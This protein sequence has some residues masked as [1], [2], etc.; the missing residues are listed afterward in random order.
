MPTNGSEV[1]III[2]DDESEERVPTK[3]TRTTSIAPSHR[4]HSQAYSSPTPHNQSWH[5]PLAR[6]PLRVCSAHSAVLLLLMLLPSLL[7]HPSNALLH[8]RHEQHPKCSFEGSTCSTSNAH[9]C[10]NGTCLSA[11]TFR[12]MKE[13]RCDMEEDDYC[14][15]C[16]GSAQERCLPAHEHGILRDNGERWERESCSWCRMQGTEREGM[17]CDDKDPQRLCLHGKCSKSVCA[18]KVQG[19]FCDRK[20]EKI[21][22]DDVCENPCARIAP[23]LMVCDCPAIDPDTGFASEDRCQLCCHDYHQKPASRRCQNAFRKYHL[24][25]AQ[26][27]PIWRIGLECAGG[28]RCNRFGICS[29]D[30]QLG[31]NGKR[32]PAIF[33]AVALFVFAVVAVLTTAAE[34]F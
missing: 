14:F 19:Q 24:K 6:F 1:V 21:C 25:S 11:C 26:E 5:F 8:H 13:C 23:H 2:A 30:A 31:D 34:T 17:A 27:R 20:E 16:C 4:P 29:N 28:K 7:I 18:D 10:H 33:I 22:V 15:L 32:T 3:Y 12:G 9:V